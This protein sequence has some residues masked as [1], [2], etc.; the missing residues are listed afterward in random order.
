MV[1]AHLNFKKSWDDRLKSGHRSEDYNDYP[2]YFR[3]L[4]QIDAKEFVDKITNAN[5]KIADE[6]VDSILAGDAYVWKDAHTPEEINN[7]KKGVLEWR[8]HSAKL[9]NEDITIG[10]KDG[11]IINS[12]SEIG[13]RGYRAVNHTHLFFRWNNDPLDIFS[14]VDKYWDATKILSGLNPESLK[15]ATPNSGDGI[16][17]KLSIFQYPMSYGRISRHR[18]P[19]ASQKILLNMT[20]SQIGKDYASGDNGTYVVEGKTKNK[21]FVENV[22]GFGDYVSIC[23]AVHH[24]A[25][26]PTYIDGH[27][28]DSPIW[29]TDQGRWFLHTMIVPSHHA[30][31]KRYSTIGIYDPE[32]N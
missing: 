13:P 23:P 6:L 31:G 26:P 9:K 25:P 14:K 2:E 28:D 30:K 7:I 18:D 24:G 11:H 32:E 20:M 4:I 5:Q 12:S 22:A 3:N 19:P 8:V 21:V 17:D 1:E 27:K 16:V 15:K 10:C 29:D